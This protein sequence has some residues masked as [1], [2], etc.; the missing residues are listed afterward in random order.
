MADCRK[1]NCSKE[2]LWAPKG[3]CLDQFGQQGHY[4]LKEE[5]NY[6]S[7]E[8][9]LNQLVIKYAAMLGRYV[10]RKIDVS[11]NAYPHHCMMLRHKMGQMS[12]ETQNLI[13]KTICNKR[14][15][16]FFEKVKRIKAELQR[17]PPSP[18][19]SHSPT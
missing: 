15:I 14:N 12:R 2:E 5:M 3:R 19:H 10:N 16:S 17:T 8:G 7:G 13:C 9:S 6:E 11:S 18:K 4:W 1:M